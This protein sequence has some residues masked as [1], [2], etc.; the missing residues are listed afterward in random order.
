MGAT[1]F[2]SSYWLSGVMSDHSG[3]SEYIGG[4]PVRLGVAEI[5]GIAARCCG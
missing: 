5:E 3:R 1:G 4:V 2:A